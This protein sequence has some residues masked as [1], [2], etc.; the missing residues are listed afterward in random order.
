MQIQ[1]RRPQVFCVTSFRLVSNEKCQDAGPTFTSR[2][3]DPVSVVSKAADMLVRQ[4]AEATRPRSPTSTAASPPD[5]HQGEDFHT[6]TASKGRTDLELLQATERESK[7]ESPEAEVL[8]PETADAESPKEVFPLSSIA[9]ETASQEREVGRSTG[10]KHFPKN[11]PAA[12]A[13]LMEDDTALDGAIDAALLAA[14]KEEAKNERPIP[15]FEAMEASIPEPASL[16]LASALSGNESAGGSSLPAA[17]NL[18][19]NSATEAVEGQVKDSP[20]LP[21]VPETEILTEP[22]L[23]TDSKPAAQDRSAVQSAEEALAGL[24]LAG[25]APTEA[26]INPAEMTD[27][28]VALA[29]TPAV[30]DQGASFAPPSL[31][32][33]KEDSQAE[34]AVISSDQEDAPEE[35]FASSEDASIASACK[36]AV[37]SP[38]LQSETP[39]EPVQTDKAEHDQSVAEHT[40]TPNDSSNIQDRGD[41]VAQGTVSVSSKQDTQMLRSPETQSTPATMAERSDEDQADSEAESSDEESY[42]VRPKLQAPGTFTSRLLAEY[43][44]ICTPVRGLPARQDGQQNTVE[45]DPDSE[46]SPKKAV[47]PLGPL[48]ELDD[49]PMEV[50]TVGEG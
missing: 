19:A 44:A 15:T 4:A 7:A 14:A 13:P 39:H 50:S 2:N 18:P 30:N 43:A 17:A 23:V 33:I 6:G 29:A 12:S 28:P 16:P 11:S 5:S 49:L 48:P 41:S 42:A 32:V 36:K 3:R 10:Q 31:P 25:I 34:P 46:V 22:S 9:E 47:K 35:E 24:S 21:T 37:S 38:E 27:Q 26:L 45:E 20:A 8:P 1:D 40:H